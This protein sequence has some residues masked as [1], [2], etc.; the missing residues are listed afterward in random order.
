MSKL[1][2]C[3]LCTAVL[4]AGTL[5]LRQHNRELAFQ[6]SKIHSEIKALQVTLWNQQLQIATATG[7]NA[8]ERTVGQYDLELVPAANGEE[9]PDEQ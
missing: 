4:A 2:I 6:S 3:I 8:I 7:P 9:T 5:Q 1:L